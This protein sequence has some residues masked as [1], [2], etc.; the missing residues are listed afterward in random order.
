M[1]VPPLD[2]LLWRA[3]LR[4]E[5]V[6]RPGARAAPLAEARDGLLADSVHSPE[7]VPAQPVAAMDGFAVHRADLDEGTTV[8]PVAADLPAR[9]GAVAALPPGTA[10]RIMTGAP[11]PHGADVVV[12][13]ESTDVDPF[14]EAP[15]EV[16]L[17]LPHLPAAGRH[18]R[19]AGEEVARGALLA[20][21]GE[22]VGAGL[23]GLA[24]ALG[25]RTLPVHQAPQVSVVVTGDELEGEAAE[26]ERSGAGPSAGAV[27]ESNGTMLAA[28]LRADGAQARVLRSGDDPS[29][30]RA[31]LEDASAG[32]DLVITTG[33]I[34]HGAYDVVKL[35]LGERGTGTSEFV[36][37]ALRPGGPQGAGALAGG[38]P[39]IH[40]PGTPAGALVG[41][42]LFVRPLI[43]GAGEGIRRVLWREPTEVAGSRHGRSAAPGTVHAL[44]ARIRL[45]PDGREFAEPVPGRRL[46]PYGRA[47]AIALLGVGSLPVGDVADGPETTVLV[48]AL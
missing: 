48:I 8:L 13:V 16:T 25:L 46:A 14:G 34:G 39:V 9:P 27:R 28:A 38:T 4:R 22:R 31:V 2:P 17:H 32:A 18:V 44:A 37:L 10:A 11:M 29:E 36:H 7:D 5:M 43:P 33:G 35:L 26:E 45:A 40:L 15:A 3:R 47:D 41:Y 42:H 30:L 23:I 24:A 12:E 20:E 1:T 19:A 21:A 6:L